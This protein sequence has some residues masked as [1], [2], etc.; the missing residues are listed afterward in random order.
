MGEKGEKLKESQPS[1]AHGPTCAAALGRYTC[2]RTRTTWVA[3]QARCRQLY[4]SRG[5]LATP[6]S[7]SDNA[8]IYDANRAQS[9]NNRT[10]FKL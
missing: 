10:D 7:S 2:S 9:T 5:R 8:A 6:H 3:A 1:G 4:G